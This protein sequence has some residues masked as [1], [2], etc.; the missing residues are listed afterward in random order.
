MA[1]LVVVEVIA[2]EVGDVQQPLDE[3]V[4]ERHEETERHHRRH[5]ANELLADAVLH[6]VALEEGDHVAGGVVGAALGHRAVQADLLPVAGAVLL[7]GER[8][9]DAA[10]D[11]QVGIAPDR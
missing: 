3:D 5:A 1:G 6:E 2:A 4:V 10:V 9:L 7:A 11:Q 8:G